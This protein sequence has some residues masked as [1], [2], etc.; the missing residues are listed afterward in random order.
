ME[1]GKK[2]PEKKPKRRYKNETTKQTK[3]FGELMWNG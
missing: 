1:K 3:N 2:M